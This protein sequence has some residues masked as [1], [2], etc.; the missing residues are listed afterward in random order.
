MLLLE[1]DYRSLCW[2]V[3]LLPP[4]TT[5]AVPSLLIYHN[6]K[7]LR[8]GGCVLCCLQR[9]YNTPWLPD[10]SGDDVI[11]DVPKTCTT[12]TVTQGCRQ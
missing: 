6:G 9:G 11:D 2:W 3:T 12:A 1:S 7:Q 4:V 8:V 5:K 10:D